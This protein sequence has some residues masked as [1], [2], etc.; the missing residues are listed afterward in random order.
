[1]GMF[2]QLTFVAML[3]LSESLCKID[4]FSSADRSIIC[5][6]KVRKEGT[7][8]STISE[9]R[10]AEAKMK[11]MLD[12]LKTPKAEEPNYLDTELRCASDE[13]TKAVRELEWT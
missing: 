3:C 4:H 12:A 2:R 13:Y 5:T 8:M 7:T 6:G 9:V 11:S 1:M 10:A